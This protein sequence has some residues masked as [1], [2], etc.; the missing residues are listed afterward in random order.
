[1]FNGKDHHDFGQ[2][3]GARPQIAHANTSRIGRERNKRPS[4]IDFIK[5]A[6]ELN[7]R[8]LSETVNSLR[9]GAVNFLWQS[10]KWRATSEHRQLLKT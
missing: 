4:K 2:A 10:I 1:M 3:I 7:P 5:S 9:L 8:T 6:K